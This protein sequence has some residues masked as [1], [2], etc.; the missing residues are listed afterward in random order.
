MPFLNNSELC[1]W[2]ISLH[3]WESIFKIKISNL[4]FKFNSNL[5]NERKME[6]LELLTN[7]VLDLTTIKKRGSEIR[8]TLKKEAGNCKLLF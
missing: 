5:L 1:S 8:R 2:C 7:I 3:G 6:T 4:T